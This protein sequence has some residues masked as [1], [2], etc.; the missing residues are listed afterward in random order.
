MGS[1]VSVFAPATVANLGPGFD[2]LGLAVA[3]P[4]DTV[5]ARRVPEPGVRLV[6]VEGDGGVLPLHADE[7]C[8]GVAARLTLAA[9]GIELGVEMR[10]TKGLPIGSGMGSSAAS[11]AA[12]AL[13]AN[14]LMGS[15]L[16]RRELVAPCVEAEARVSGRHADNVAPALLGGLVMVRTLDPLDIIRLP[17]PEQLR[18][19]VITPDLVVET[20]RAREILPAEVSLGGA[21][22]HAA[23]L[24]GLV[25][26]CY[27]GDLELLSRCL[28][29]E[30]VAPR[31]AELVPGAA[32]AM[33]AARDAG[34]LGSSISGSGPSVF[35]LCRSERSA[36]EVRAVMERAF[37]EVGHGHTAIISPA[38]S[39]GARRL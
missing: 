28:T 17:I 5:I 36:R 15:P 7:N 37:D 24:A 38:D 13:A 25:S 33:D 12:G 32:A 6:G 19:V 31:R 35:A 39:P 14:L 26:A 23:D 16:R 9:A 8:A 4:G 22:R 3:G 27:T 1:E 2:V 11:A 21:V 10:L 30:L 18:V 34:A 29:D 20:R